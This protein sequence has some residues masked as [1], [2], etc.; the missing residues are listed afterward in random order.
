MPSA[1]AYCWASPIQ[2]QQEKQRRR[3]EKKR[4]NDGYVVDAGQADWPGEVEIANP[5][6]V[7]WSRQGQISGCLCSAVQISR[8]LMHHCLACLPQVPLSTLSHNQQSTR[9]FTMHHDCKDR[10]ATRSV[11][12]ATR[13]RRQRGDVQGTCATRGRQQTW[14]Q[15]S[16]Q[17]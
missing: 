7:R 12:A 10:M 1:R 3:E 11:V 8:Q 14:E 16:I 6:A 13:D 15:Y 17:A 4:E 2:T 5:P 9:Q